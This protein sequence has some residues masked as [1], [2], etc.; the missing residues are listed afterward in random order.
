M[1]GEQRKL[2]TLCIVQN[3]A[4]VLLGMKKRGFGV[5]R[6]NGFGGKVKAGETLRAAAEREVME[7]AGIEVHDVMEVGVLEFQFQG[8]P[9]V[10]EVHVFKAESFRGEPRESDEMRPRWF[11]VGEIPFDEMW[12]DDRYWVPLFLEGQKFKGRFLFG[13]GDV[14]LEKE[15]HEVNG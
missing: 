8:N 1:A 12:P 7:E 10:L 3:G 9:E 4:R 2:L 6:W 14:V 13:E 15:L 5:G 11:P